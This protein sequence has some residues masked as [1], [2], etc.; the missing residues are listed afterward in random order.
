MVW[1]GAVQQGCREPWVGSGHNR[2][3]THRIYRS[4]PRAPV[5]AS[6][7]L[8]LSPRKDSERRDRRPVK[9]GFRV[10]TDGLSFSISLSQMVPGTFIY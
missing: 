9:V 8:G 10:T 4:F 7:F 6:S 5:G 1:S 2:K 3:D